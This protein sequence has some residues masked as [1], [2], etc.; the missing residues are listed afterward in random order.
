MTLKAAFAAG[1]QL[2]LFAARI[3]DF[4]TQGIPDIPHLRDLIL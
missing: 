4:I 3:Y 1:Q 2:F